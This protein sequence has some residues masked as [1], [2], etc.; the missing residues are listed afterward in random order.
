MYSEQY[1][2]GLSSLMYYYCMM[3][4]AASGSLSPA[5]I[6]CVLS[7]EQDFCTGEADWLY[8]EASRSMVTSPKKL[9]PS[10]QYHKVL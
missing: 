1:L 6:D 4:I 3:T 7:L 10:K 9:G 2:W 5:V 8:K